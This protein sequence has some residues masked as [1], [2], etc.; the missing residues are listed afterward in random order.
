[1]L[2][3]NAIVFILILVSACDPAAMRDNNT[4]RLPSYDEMCEQACTAYNN[5][6]R[7]YP[8]HCGPDCAVYLEPE[9]ESE[10]D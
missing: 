8:D 5:G 7:E 10:K 3:F 6:I 9:N 4:Y 2:K 1:M